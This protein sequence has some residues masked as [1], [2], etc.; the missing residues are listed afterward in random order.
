VFARG[1]KLC[2][3]CCF[4][5]AWK[6]GNNAGGGS[7]TSTTVANGIATIS[8]SSTGSTITPSTSQTSGGIA[9]VLQ[10]VRGRHLTKS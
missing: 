9:I 1:W 5:G 4:G 6:G 2:D 3:E 10:N 7:I 8:L